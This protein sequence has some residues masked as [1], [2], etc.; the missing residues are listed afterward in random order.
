MYWNT[1]RGESAKGLVASQCVDTGR[2]V[3]R[4]LYHSWITELFPRY[5][6]RLQTSCLHPPNDCSLGNSRSAQH[7]VQPAFVSSAVSRYPF[8]LR[9]FD[10]FVLHRYRFPTPPLHFEHCLTRDRD[11]VSLSGEGGRL[12]RHSPVGSLAT[13][14]LIISRIYS[15]KEPH[16]LLKCRP[17]SWRTPSTIPPMARCAPP[18]SCGSR[19]STC[20]RAGSTVC[21][22]HELLTKQER[23]LMVEKMTTTRR[24]ELTDEQIRLFSSRGTAVS[25]RW[26]GDGG[27]ERVA[28]G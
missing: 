8:I 11:T 12:R 27:G 6:T 18:R 21:G 14:A 17:R 25:V 22:R 4:E 7:V 1:Q 3:L 20:R 24:I 23:L 15:G 13:V 9:S 2:R 5:C 19:V 26:C 10:P 16:N 28:G